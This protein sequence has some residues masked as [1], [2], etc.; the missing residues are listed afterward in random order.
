MPHSGS[1]T[2]ICRS[3]NAL[4]TV[5]AYNTHENFNHRQYGGTFQLTFGALAAKV[6][7]TGVDEYNLG[8]FAWLKFKGRNRHTARI[9]SIYVPCHTG[10]SSGH[11]TVM[12]QHHQC[13]DDKDRL[14]CPRT[15]LLEDIQT[16][17][18]TWWH[19]RECLLVVIIDANANMTKGP[20]HDMFMDP[21]KQ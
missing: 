20:F 15:I 16:L 9:V 1:L 17:L 13:F 19:S 6:V 21:G 14:D 2:K 4:R 12:N 18:Q 3:V 7:E 5:A 8:W 10:R 11:L